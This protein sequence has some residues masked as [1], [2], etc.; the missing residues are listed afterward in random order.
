MS[1]VW[2]RRRRWRVVEERHGTGLT[3]LR[4]VAR[5]TGETR[6]FLIPG[7]VAVAERWPRF[8]H[9]RPRQALARLAGHVAIAR[10]AFT[11]GPL[12]HA[13]ISIFPFQLEPTLALLAGR[14]RLLIADDV[15]MGKTVQAGLLVRAT[16][17]QHPDARVLVVAPATLLPQWNGELATRF[18]L[19]PRVA[20]TVALAKLRR[21][22]PYLASP[23]LLPGV[24]LT[25]LDFLKQPHVLDALPRAPWDLIVIDEAHQLSGD[26]QR[27]DAMND[28]ATAARTVVL[29]TATPHDGDET[30]FRRLLSVGSGGEP[31]T[32]FRRTREA[33]S[34]RRHVRWLPV[35]LSDHDTRA[36]QTIDMFERSERPSPALAVSDGLPLIC[37]VFRRRLL[38]SPAA[39]HASLIRRLAIIEQR[40]ISTEDG[41]RQQGLFDTD[42][43]AVD[44]ADALMG[45]SG[46]S[47]ERE[48]AWLMRLTHLCSRHVPGSRARALTTLLR[49]CAD[50]AIVF[51][52]YRDTL[53]SIVAAL[54]DDRR[55]VVMHGGQTLAE[56]QHA[57]TTFLERRADVL[58][59]TDVASQGLNLHTTARWA[60]CLDVPATPLRLAQRIGRID[61]IG[62]TRRVHGTV[63]TSRHAFD[64]S[65]R[66]RLDARAAQSATASLA[67]CR[68]WTRAAIGLGAWY[69]RQRRLAAH[70]RHEPASDAC[71]AVVTPAL[72]RRWLGRSAPGVSA[73][74]I[75]L[76]TPSGE[77]VERVIVAADTDAPPGVLRQHAAARAR[78][79]THRLR[80][81]AAL[82]VRTQAL[83]VT[84]AQ[85]GLFAPAVPTYAT[86]TIT[87]HATHATHATDVV[88]VIAGEPRL[89]VQLLARVRGD[90][91]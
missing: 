87:T 28:L 12:N 63:L 39:L 18:G 29:L 69:G 49:R 33:D 62:Q 22:L 35:R 57:L 45:V 27:H 59:A 52:Q 37:A 42:L 85:P 68:R 86:N 74:E 41:W 90:A 38:S 3:C 56:Q 66:D 16:L 11:P 13:N 21:A 58:V 5:D 25:S 30:R 10:V 43:F 72:V 73:Y 54:P 53:P 71:V 79:L 84:S 2:I 75:P 23:W 19:A 32:I 50:R 17:D 26:S 46:L 24:W 61:R 6:G 88:S 60:I 78:V 15:G 4:A 44:E 77:V 80:L 14:R 8:V 76:M 48:R 40:P 55:G 91:E 81:R 20:D 89:L 9:V 67:S 34:R 82:R 47:F 36:L 1:D 70:W 7:D 64:R 65:L 51:T 31:P 83:Q